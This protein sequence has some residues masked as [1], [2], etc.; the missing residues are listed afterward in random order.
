MAKGFRGGFGGMGGNMGAIMQQAQKMQRD[1]EVAKAEI[2]A[3]EVDATAG[4]GDVKG[5][6]RIEASVL[7][8]E[9][10]IVPWPGFHQALPN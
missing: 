2:D 7:I 8:I 3:M 10:R 6:G 1:I 4:G 9:R 5:N